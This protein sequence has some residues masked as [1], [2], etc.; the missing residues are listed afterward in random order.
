MS[1]VFSQKSKTNKKQALAHF[2]RK[3]IDSGAFKELSMIFFINLLNVF[4]LRFFFI[5]IQ[6]ITTRGWFF[7]HNLRTF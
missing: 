3:I 4:E 5:R 1:L 2:W 7:I 6:F